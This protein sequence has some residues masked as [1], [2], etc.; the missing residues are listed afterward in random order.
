M[1]KLQNSAGFLL[2]LWWVSSSSDPFRLPEWWEENIGSGQGSFRERSQVGSRFSESLFLDIP[3][4]A[5]E[6]VRTCGFGKK[7][8]SLDKAPKIRDSVRLISLES[9][10]VTLPSISSETW[11]IYYWAISGSSVLYDW[12]LLV[13]LSLFLETAAK[14]LIFLNVAH[15]SEGKVLSVVK[16]ELKFCFS[17]QWCRSP[18][19]WGKRVSANAN[20]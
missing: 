2:V 5:T 4:M 14:L 8:S 9:F 13:F 7:S 11:D 1:Y 16:T 15:D 20:S 18:L 10:L 3:E 12:L 6:Q 17:Q 19:L